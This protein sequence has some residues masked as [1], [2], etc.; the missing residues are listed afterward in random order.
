[1]KKLAIFDFDGTLVDT[2][3]D[4]VAC[5][6]RALEFHG[7]P[8]LV[9]DEFVNRLGG[10]INEIVSLVLEDN[11]TPENIKLIKDTYKELYDESPKEKSIPFR[12]VHEL[13]L[14]LQND[15][16]LIAINSNRSTDSI[17]LFTDRYFDDVD[18]LL[19]EGHNFNYPSKPSPIGVEKIIEKADVSLGET[20][21]IG[22]SKTDIKTAQNA[23]IDCIIVTWG[24][25][26]EKDYNNSYPIKI[27]DETS[28]LKYIQ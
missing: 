15:G 11:A 7:F 28:Q 1:M 22:D 18:F 10:N 9:H 4:V 14:N 23:Q 27:V 19:I 5:M 20:V 13:L 8:T 21:Y 12:G 24:Y 17:K 6:N 25:G 26:N 2:V 16:V 3:H